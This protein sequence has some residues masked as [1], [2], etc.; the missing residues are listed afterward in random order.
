MVT[1]YLLDR[2]TLGAVVATVIALLA[3]KAR[4]LTRT[5]AIAAF[6]TG[7]ICVAAGWSWG[8]LL[9][10]L[11]VTASILS[12]IGA[13]RKEELLGPV[14]EK[15]GAR[16]AWQVAANG[17][18]YA[19]AAAGVICC[20]GSHWYAL[21]I[22]ALAAS[23]ADTWSTEIG[24]LGDGTPRLIASG[25]IVPTGTSG[26]ITLAGNAGAVVGAAAA[27]LAAIAFGWPV[28]FFAAFAGGIAGAFGDSLLGATIQSKRWCED[29]RLATERKIHTCGAPT[30]PAGGWSWLDND[31]VNF[32]STIIGGL[33]ALLLSAFGHR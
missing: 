14:V 16:D 27:A 8:I 5:G 19:T 2:V 24:T 26:G 12:R 33:V 17:S 21:G 28:S 10:G 30:L 18:V 1:E 3:Y 31:G 20:G 29:C 7:A 23:T 13:S 25:K 6:L 11:F 22:G 9:L 32:V 4:T 15:T